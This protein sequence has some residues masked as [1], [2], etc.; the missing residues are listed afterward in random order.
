MHGIPSVQRESEKNRQLDVKTQAKQAAEEKAGAGNPV[1]VYKM[2]LRFFKSLSEARQESLKD[3]FLETT[4]SLTAT[5]SEK[6]AKER[7]EYAGVTFIAA[8]F[9][10]F[11]IEQKGF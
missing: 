10:K 1:P 11:L 9:K 6:G 7:Q 8:N 2:A 5:E 3:E 4:D